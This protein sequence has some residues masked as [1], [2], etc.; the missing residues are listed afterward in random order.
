[1]LCVSEMMVNTDNSRIISAFGP[2]F[3]ATERTPLN[4]RMEGHNL[5]SDKK[6]DLFINNIQCVVINP[7]QKFEAVDDVRCSNTVCLV[8]VDLFLINS[9]TVSDVEEDSNIASMKFSLSPVECVDV[10]P[11]T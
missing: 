8:D 6:E 2:V 4:V 1:M 10:E 11:R 5:I 3:S 9:G 7:G